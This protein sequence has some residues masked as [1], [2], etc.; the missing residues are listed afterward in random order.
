MYFTLKSVFFYFLVYYIIPFE[1]P[2]C[3]R[4]PLI[5]T[6]L[7]SEVRENISFFFL[8]KGQYLEEKQRLMSGAQRQDIHLS[9]FIFCILGQW[10]EA[11]SWP[12]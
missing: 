6:V 1:G 8:K 7:N 11:Q 9:L 4:P 5:S 10:T 12:A 3:C 2:F